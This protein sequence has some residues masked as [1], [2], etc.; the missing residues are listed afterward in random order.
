MGK[1]HSASALTIS[2]QGLYGILIRYIREHICKAYDDHIVGCQLCRSCRPFIGIICITVTVSVYSFIKVSCYGSGGYKMS[3]FKF[4]FKD[5]TLFFYLG[6]IIV[7]F[8]RH[9][10]IIRT[11]R[12]DIDIISRYILKHL[13]PVTIWI[14]VL[15]I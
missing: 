15:K 13:V 4:Y 14:I 1:E 10:K 7:L 6:R 12:I 5:V 2:N 11:Y 8:I 9:T 3:T